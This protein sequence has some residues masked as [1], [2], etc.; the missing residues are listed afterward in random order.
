MIEDGAIVAAGSVADGA[1]EPAFAD[2]GRADE[3]EGVR[4]RGCAGLAQ[5]RRSEEDW[6]PCEHTGFLLRCM[7]IGA[8]KW[9]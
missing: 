9:V 3:G 8:E 1:G 7:S 4:S 2:A 5:T 6:R